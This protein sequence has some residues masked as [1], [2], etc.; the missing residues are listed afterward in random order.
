MIDVCLQYYMIT[1][2]TGLKFYLMPFNGPQ[3]QIEK[4]QTS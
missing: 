4:N 1:T 2:F 3:T